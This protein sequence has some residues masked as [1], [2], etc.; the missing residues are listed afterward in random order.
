MALFVFVGDAP[1][2][3]AYARSDAILVTLQRVEVDGV[4]EVRGEEFIALPFEAASC[5]GQF[6]QFG[7]SGGEAFVQGC[8]DLVRQGRV[9]GLGDA[10]LSVAVGDELFRDGDGHGA[11]GAGGS[12]A[13]ASGARV[14]G[15]VVSLLVACHPLL[16]P[17]PA[18]PAEQGALQVVVVDAL[19]LPRRLAR[20][21]EHLGLLPRLN[22]DQRFVGTGVLSTPVLDGAD[23]GL[24]RILKNLDLPTGCGGFCGVG[25]VVRPRGG[26][27]GV[28]IEDSTV[29]FGVFLE[30][31][32]DQ[33]CAER[34]EFD[35]SVL[36]PL[37]VAFADVEVADGCPHGVPPVATFCRNPLLTSVARYLE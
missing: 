1:V 31:P 36:A 6:G 3:V 28:K 9:L 13:G 34:I 7:G 17:R 15:V 12:F 37:G 18:A 30:R 19:P 2:D 35:G 8:R 29:A 32:L 16:H 4:G 10:D 20:I 14:V 24:R 21:E 25:T 33:R 23:Y 5:G 27:L 22:V 11:P 26:D